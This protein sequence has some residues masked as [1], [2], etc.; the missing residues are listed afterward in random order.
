MNV[1]TK[2]EVEVVCPFCKSRITLRK[3]KDASSLKFTCPSCDKDLYATFN[4]NVS[5]QTYKI[6]N[7]ID[8]DNDDIVR[9]QKGKTVY[10]KTTERHDD[11]EDDTSK[12]RIQKE[13]PHHTPKA[14]KHEEYEEYETSVAPPKKKR[15]LRENIYL[16]QI[17]W[18][19]IKDQQYS[20]FEGKTVIGRYDPEYPSDIS[21]T[22]DEL[23]SRRSVL[24]T[25]EE[26]HGVFIYK[27]KVLNATN[28]VKVNGVTVREGYETYLEFGDIITM[29]N[30]KFRFDNH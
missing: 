22:G 13:R 17:K 30:T 14:H 16:T 26:E 9:S 6:N 12:T 1:D 28:K 29:G 2:I 23:M 21:I 27:L 5:P 15:Q 11:Y 8:N 7:G 25:I 20:L 10:S 19:G 3:K 4:V 18:F 24:I